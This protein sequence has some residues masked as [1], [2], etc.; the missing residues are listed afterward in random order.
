MDDNYYWLKCTV[1]C[2]HHGWALLL[3]KG[4]TVGAF[5]V[6]F[7]MV[8]GGKSCLLALYLLYCKGNMSPV[9]NNSIIDSIIALDYNSMSCIT[10]YR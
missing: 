2:L 8:P 3:F 9:A 10:Y 7:Y 6:S 4:R 1:V 5:C